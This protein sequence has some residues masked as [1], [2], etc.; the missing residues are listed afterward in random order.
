MLAPRRLTYFQRTMLV[1]STYLGL[2]GFPIYLLESPRT[3]VIP[4]FLKNE[5]PKCEFPEVHEYMG[6]YGGVPN[7]VR[8]P[9]NFPSFGYSN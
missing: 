7:A 4:T 1:C 6:P 9:H 5:A 8:V 2:K 3:Y